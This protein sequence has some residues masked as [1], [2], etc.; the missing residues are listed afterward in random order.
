LFGDIP[1]NITPT[2]TPTP[3]GTSGGDDKNKEWESS[4]ESQKSALRTHLEGMGQGWKNYFSKQD[5]QWLA[6][7][8]KTQE[9]TSTVTS[10]IG[11]TLGSIDAI[12]QQRHEN[13]MI[14]LDNEQ[15]VEMSNLEAR[16][17]SEKEFASEK[18]D[19]DKKYA[20]KKKELE[21]ASAKRA[22]RMALFQAILGTA[23]GIANALPVIPLAILAG[24]MG[25]MQIAA[26]A[27]QPIPMA[28]GALAYSPTNA[29]VGDNINAKNDPEVIAPLSKLEQIMGK[30]GGNNVRVTG[31]I[32]GNEIVLS[33]EK[34]NIGLARYA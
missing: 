34:A 29:I 16:G 31:Q 27:S 32:S 23:Q 15:A 6:W 5:A 21:I 1:E 2:P 3:T 10:F 22:K 19:I 13:K 9:I 18:A 17:L 14:T 30:G 20:G 8:D 25:A 4:L 33:S 11:E 7:G 26:I 12:A 24:V 28:G